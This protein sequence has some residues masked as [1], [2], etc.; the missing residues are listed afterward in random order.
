M[1]KIPG[2]VPVPIIPPPPPKKKEEAVETPKQPAP[3]RPAVSR[4]PYELDSRAIAVRMAALATDAK[5]RELSFEEIIEKV[6]KETGLTDVQAAFEEAN[7]KLQK[8]IEEELEKIKK[9]KELMEEAGSWQ[10]LAE[11]LEHKL[12]PDQLKTFISML[13]A[14]I[15]GVRK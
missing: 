10:E 1:V 9:N 13:E 14:E 7:R 15:K 11:L 5:E 12:S 8:E 3:S 4:E 6:I 2:S